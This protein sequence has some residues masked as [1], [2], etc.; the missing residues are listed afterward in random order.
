[1]IKRY[2]LEHPDSIGESYTEHF[3]TAAKFSGAMI[4]GGV[5]CFVHA[6]V[7]GLFV[8]TGSGIIAKLHDRMVLGRGRIRL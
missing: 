1:M 4:L 5:A 2:F 3:R 8:K 6:L 7:P